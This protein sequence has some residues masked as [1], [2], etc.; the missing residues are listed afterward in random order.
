LGNLINKEKLDEIKANPAQII[1]G[2]NG[3]S[4]NSLNAIKIKLNKNKI[5]KL[6]FLK[7]VEELETMDRKEFAELIADKLNAKLIEIRG[8]NLILQKKDI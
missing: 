4:E 1:I 5:V 6:K 2:K 3:L 8:Y 7:T